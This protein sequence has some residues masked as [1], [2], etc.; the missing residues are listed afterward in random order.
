MVLVQVDDVKQ[1]RARVESLGVRVVWSMEYPEAHGVHFHPRDVG[2]AI[3]SFD[4]MTPPDSWKWGGPEWKDHV[5]TDVI[6][7]I[8][9]AELQSSDAGALADQWAKVFNVPRE[10]LGDSVYKITVNGGY[11]RFVPV[12]GCCGC[13]SRCCCS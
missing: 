12:S 6:T 13:C 7:E 1:E 10:D 5:K 4:Q 11:L 3:L 9:G 2:A 8:I